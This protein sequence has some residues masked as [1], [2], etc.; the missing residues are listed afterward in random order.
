MGGVKRK[1]REDEVLIREGLFVF[2]EYEGDTPHLI[3][4][5]CKKCGDV[6]FPKSELCSACDSEET[7]EEI[8]MGERGTL[9]TY[10]I[11]RVG[12]PNYDLPYMLGLVE[13]PEGKNLRIMAQLEGCTEDKVRIGMPLELTIG[14]IR[15]DSSAGKTIIG[16][17]YRPV[18]E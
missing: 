14:K 17:K 4:G 1:L 6:D 3:G 8:L 16:Y 7:T 15:A 12:F 13:L 2:P 10:T 5:K 11:V 18:R 9:H